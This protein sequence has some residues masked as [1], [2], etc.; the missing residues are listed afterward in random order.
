MSAPTAIIAEDEAP[1]RAE[2]GALL[3][4]LWPELQVLEACADGRQAIAALKQ[5]RP[6]FA[7]LDIRMP[8]ATGM[9]VAKTADASTHI[10]FI[11]AYDTFAVQAFE[12]G[13]V[14]YLLKPI[15][16]ERLKLTIRRLSARLEAAQPANMEDVLARLEARLGAQPD[17]IKWIT[18]SA[19]GAVRM[20]AIEDVL[21][22]QSQDKH[23]RVVTATDEVHIRK[24][25]T[26]LLSQLDPDAFWQVHRSA[27]VKV[28]AIRS[29]RR[30]EDGKLQ[31]QVNGRA[32]KL[33]VSPTFAARFR[34]M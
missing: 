18:A 26:E 10:V 23:T 15:D 20:V 24:P 28:S 1:L 12:E 31:L 22:F 11:T 21:F 4:E 34:G 19:G 2:L 27:V 13:A 33:A 32:E 8:G 5:H 30:D 16:R 6:A 3:A 7:F 14:D 29:V 9:Q 25:L 17:R